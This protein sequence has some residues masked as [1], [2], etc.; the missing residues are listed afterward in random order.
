MC[1]AGVSGARVLV[2]CMACARVSGAAVHLIVGVRALLVA[3]HAQMHSVC[4]RAWRRQRTEGMLQT[5]GIEIA[6]S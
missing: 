3:A 6:I 1:V 2:L 4:I 5:G